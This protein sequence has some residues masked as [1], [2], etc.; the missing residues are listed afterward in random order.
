MSG[1]DAL[2]VLQL[3][4]R[5]TLR[6]MGPEYSTTAAEQLVMGTA[7]VESNFMWL[8]QHN[9]GPALSLWQ[10]EP[11]TFRDLMERCSSS[12]LRKIFDVAQLGSGLAI[13]PEVMAWNLRFGA[14]MCR[15]KYRDDPHPLP[16]PGDVHALA[17]VYKRCYNTV[18]G[19]G[20]V[21]GFERAWEDFI[22]PVVEAKVW[23]TSGGSLTTGTEG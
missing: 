5:P 13:T 20:T 4:V 12:L 10:I 3:A 16:E 6:A 9:H 22:R 15:L 23:A 2:H 19:K 1:L 17:V 21:E 7:A 18:H 11:F 14:A 8:R